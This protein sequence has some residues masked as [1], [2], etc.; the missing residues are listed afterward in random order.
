[1]RGE[2]RGS[3]HEQLHVVLYICCCILV[4]VYSARCAWVTKVIQYPSDTMQIEGIYVLRE[5]QG[6]VLKKTQS[7]QE[8][9]RT[10][11][12]INSAQKSTSAQCHS[13]SFHHNHHHGVS[14]TTP[15]TTPSGG[16]T[17]TPDSHFPS[18][19]LQLLPPSNQACLFHRR[20]QTRLALPTS[21]L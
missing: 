10:R 9:Q 21:F 12:E 6:T 3:S 20:I 1:M 8:S 5:T 13:T 7:Q 4:V 15:T 19:G 11:K 16:G 17:R 14:L 2:G 18:N